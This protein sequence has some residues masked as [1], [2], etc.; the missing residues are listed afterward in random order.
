MYYLIKAFNIIK[1]D[2]IKAITEDEVL[3]YINDKN[4]PPPQLLEMLENNEIEDESNPF[5]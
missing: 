5:M 2:D 3:D 4:K 1:N